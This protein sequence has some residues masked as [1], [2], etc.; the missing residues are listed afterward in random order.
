VDIRAHEQDSE[1]EKYDGVMFYTG[2]FGYLTTVLRWDSKKTELGAVKE[3][4]KFLSKKITKDWWANHQEQDDL[5][6][7]DPY[8]EWKGSMRGD[9]LGNKKFYE[10]PDVI[11]LDG[12][13]ILVI[14]C[15]S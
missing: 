11:D 5:F 1:D 2:R 7:N 13:C 3:A 8:S 14:R 6:H 12:N 9:L 15:G 4:E 10:T